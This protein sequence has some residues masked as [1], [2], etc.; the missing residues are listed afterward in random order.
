M[1]KDTLGR[2]KDALLKLDQNLL[3]D[4]ADWLYF[5]TYWWHLSQSLWK[6][7]SLIE[8]ILYAENM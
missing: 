3:I 5:V 8:N 7:Q 6:V 2:N 1:N 4:I